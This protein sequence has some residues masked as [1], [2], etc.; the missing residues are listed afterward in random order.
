MY[1]RIELTS[2]DGIRRIV[3]ID[4]KFSDETSQKIQNGSDVVVKLVLPKPKN[5]EKIAAAFF[6]KSRRKMFDLAI[7]NAAFF[8]RLEGNKIQKIQA[9]FG[10]SDQ[11]L[12]NSNLNGPSVAKN[13]VKL[14][15]GMELKKVNFASDEVRDAVF[16]DVTV[17]NGAPG[18]FGILRKTLAFTF[19]NDFFRSVCDGK[20]NQ[21]F[22][23]PAEKKFHQLFKTVSADQPGSQVKLV[24]QSQHLFLKGSVLH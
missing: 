5:D 13:T 17:T 19:L 15:T 21:T 8:A 7:L 22:E 24:P 6:R 2:G 4:E 3:H 1:C 9:V 11:V 23:K 20:L 14:L 16:S 12:V 18:N 10:G